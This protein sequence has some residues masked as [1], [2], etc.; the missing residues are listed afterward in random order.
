MPR[1]GNRVY[2]D[3]FNADLV[4]I[5]SFDSPAITANAGCPMARSKVMR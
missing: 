5:T 3:D 4:L 2:A 1:D